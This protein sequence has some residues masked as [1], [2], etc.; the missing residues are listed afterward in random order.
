[1]A[2]S[3]NTSDSAQLKS[4]FMRAWSRVAPARAA[5]WVALS[6]GRCGQS[7]DPGPIEEHDQA[8][9]QSLTAVPV[10]MHFIH[11]RSYVRVC[12]LH[13]SDQLE[14][15]PTTSC[16]ALTSCK[17]HPS[18]QLPSIWRSRTTLVCGPNRRLSLPSLQLCLQWWQARCRSTPG[19]SSGWRGYW[20]WSSRPH[21]PG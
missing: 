6:G 20:C 10:A 13:I 17:P 4:G 15:A 16:Q 3:I 9:R 8:L 1:M 2:S 5:E 7:T 19:Q 14:H 12:H 11:A 18:P 21:R